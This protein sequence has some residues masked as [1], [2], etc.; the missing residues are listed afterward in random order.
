M[1]CEGNG[2]QCEGNGMV[3]EGIGKVCKVF[4]VTT[5]SAGA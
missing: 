1:V 4:D 5:G 2:M 3:C